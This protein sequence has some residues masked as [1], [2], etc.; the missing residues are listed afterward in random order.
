MQALFLV[1]LALTV[2]SPQ[3]DRYDTCQCFCCKAASSCTTAPA[4]GFPALTGK[5]AIYGDDASMCSAGLC[6]VHFPAACPNVLQEPGAI[7][8]INLTCESCR[9]QISSTVGRK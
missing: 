8:R 4:T 3:D 2:A 9:R 5:F 7:V 1:L 6:N